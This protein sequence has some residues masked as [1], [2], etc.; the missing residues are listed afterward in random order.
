M[1]KM[2]RR[3]KKGWIIMAMTRQGGAKRRVFKRDAHGKS[4]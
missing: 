2:R 4:Q 3:K 1:V